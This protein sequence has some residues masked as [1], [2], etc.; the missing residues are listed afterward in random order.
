MWSKINSSLL[1]QYELLMF[2]LGP[3]AHRRAST[4]VSPVV[5]RVKCL[6]VKDPLDISLVDPGLFSMFAQAIELA[7]P[8]RV[9]RAR[10]NV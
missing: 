8:Q 1:T 5:I 4:L 7:C 6:G 3:P 2:L 9:V 10:G